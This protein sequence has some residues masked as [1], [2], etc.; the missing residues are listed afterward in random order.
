MSQVETIAL[1][2]GLF[3]SIAGI[4]LSVVATLFA[5]WVNKGATEVNN[6]TIKSLQ[7]I[8]SSVDQLSRDTRELITAAWNRMLGD[9]GGSETAQTDTNA[10]EQISGGI[11]NEI[12]SELAEEIP[13]APGQ[14]IER[15]EQALQDLQ[16]T[17]AA[18]LRARSN[19][20]RSNSFDFLLKR[21]SALSVEARALLSSV[22]SGAHLD[23]NQY[24][25]A[26][27]STVLRGPLR[28]LRAAGLIVP[29]EGLDENQEGVPVYWLP[30][31]PKMTR[32]ALSM[33][34]E[35]P[36]ETG[37]TIHQA[38]REIGYKLESA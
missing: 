31:T 2:T 38:L 36:V 10:P 29:L 18:Q 13:E 19:S 6:Q 8:E 16:R 11:A 5:I 15:I 26:A 1:W 22:A 7:K 4:V 17:V 35:P 28:E 32:L 23:R 37:K 21:I 30:G 14:K 3:A 34:P 33:L 12:R 27:K 9:M 25:T 20:S 24:R